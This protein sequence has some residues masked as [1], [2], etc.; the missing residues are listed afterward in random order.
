MAL[1]KIQETK[2][3]LNRN[4]DKVSGGKLNKMK[5]EFKPIYGD[6]VP[7]KRRLVKTMM[8]NYMVL[9]FS[10]VFHYGSSEKGKSCSGFGI[11]LPLKT[12]KLN[13]REKIVPYPTF[14]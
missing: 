6:V 7:T 2:M 8:F 5:K 1:R 11:V 10:S 4:P 9:K 14:P 12:S 13:E 3:V